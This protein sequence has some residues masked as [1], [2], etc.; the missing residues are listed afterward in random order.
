MSL[1]DCDSCKLELTTAGADVG[2]V[3]EA[4]QVCNC[5]CGI[6]FAA[7]QGLPPRTFVSFD[8]VAWVQR[9]LADV[10]SVEAAVAYLD[11]LLKRNR[12]RW[13]H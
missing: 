13:V 8:A 9:R 3:V 1:Q 2:K 6:S 5:S 10:V 7:N 4:M 11:E 12:I